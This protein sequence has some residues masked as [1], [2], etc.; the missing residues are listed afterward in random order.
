MLSADIAY[1]NYDGKKRYEGHKIRKDGFTSYMSERVNSKY[2]DSEG[3]SELVRKFNN[4]EGFNL[5]YLSA[6][7]SNDTEPIDW[8]IGEKLSECYLEDHKHAR[9]PYNYDRDAK[10]TRASLAGA[11]LVGLIKVDG[12]N[13]LLF[14]EVKTS[15]EDKHPPSVVYNN[16]GMINQLNE[17]KSQERKRRELVL[18]LGHKICSSNQSDITAYTKAVTQYISSDYLK[19]K[20]F[21]VMVRDMP[22]QEDDLKLVFDRVRNGSK[23]THIELLALYIPIKI[24]ELPSI[25]GRPKN[26]K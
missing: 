2:Y 26:E 14:G 17:L 1:S 19:F 11:D 3:T 20:I 24:S 15:K 16:N 5:S 18:W 13:M 4:I 25:L 7:F 6:F 23:E 8:K 22:P 12:C 9:F 10:N 21:G